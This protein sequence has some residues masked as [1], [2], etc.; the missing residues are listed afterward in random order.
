MW[1]N[2]SSLVPLG[3][4]LR[5]SGAFY[6]KK[7]NQPVVLE[8]WF[9]VPGLEAQIRV[10]KGAFSPYVVLFSRNKKT[11]RILIPGRLNSSR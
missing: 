11:A 3:R 6:S 2:F 1:L 5:V 4:I 8:E 10:G 7:P 9:R